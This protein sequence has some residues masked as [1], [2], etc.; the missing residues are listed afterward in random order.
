MIKQNSMSVNNDGNVSFKKKQCLTDAQKETVLKNLG[1]TQNELS[2]ASAGDLS[3]GNSLLIDTEEGMK[4]LPATLLAKQ[5]D[6]DKI[7]KEFY[8]NEVTQRLLGNRLDESEFGGSSYVTHDGSVQILPNINTQ[9]Y[10]GFCPCLPG[11]TLYYW[12]DRTDGTDCSTFNG[13]IAFFDLNKNYISSISSDGKTPFEAI[14]PENSFYFR[15]P[16][17]KVGDGF[18]KTVVAGFKINNFIPYA[19]SIERAKK[20]IDGIDVAENILDL[21]ACTKGQGFINGIEDGVE[22]WNSGSTGLKYWQSDFIDV[23]KKLLFCWYGYDTNNKYTIW[24]NLS[25]TF[26]DKDKKPLYISDGGASRADLETLRFNNNVAY[27]RIPISI[28]NA[29]AIAIGYSKF[30]KYVP[31]GYKS[32]VLDSLD[33][34]NELGDAENKVP[35]QKLLTDSIS[36]I[37]SVGSQ[38]AGKNWYAYGTSI[39]NTDAEGKYASYLAELSKMNL[40]NKGISGGGIGNLG[41]WSQ[42]QVF[43]AICNINDGKINAD[44]ITLE[45]G[46]NDCNSEVP[47]GTIYDTTQDTLAGCLNMCIRYL[48]ANTNAQIAI[49]PSVATNVEPNADNQYYKWQLM[50]KEICF[51]NRVY[52]IEPACNLG[53]GKLTGPDGAL[54]IADNIHQTDLG[55]YILAESMWEQI[56]RI[57]TFKTAIPN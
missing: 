16:I 2:K 36:E 3:A 26:Y 5:S 33:I 53:Y 22:V 18:R 23:R 10:T 42:G 35:S 49:M 4:G 12:T 43:N 45:T 50:I 14:V 1:M 44:L 38:W 56:K 41:A 32:Q 7:P 30:S 54:Y 51:I 55:G 37:S 19:S 34:V 17:I 11:E 48:Q 39:T 28:A 20:A 40:T 6:L 47:L 29:N 15:I 8:T 24:R 13:T 46:A 31:Y 9:T 57:P 25:F 52:F 21:D 27:V